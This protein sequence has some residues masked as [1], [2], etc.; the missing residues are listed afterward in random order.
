[1][2]KARFH[3]EIFWPKFDDYLDMV[4][5]A[6]TRPAHPCPITRLDIMLR[7]LVRELQR[8]S[9][10]KIGGIREQ[11]LMARELVL[12]LDRAQE[13][14]QLPEHVGELRR[15]MKMRCL[16]LSS[17]ERTMARQRSRVRQLSEGDANTAY[18][19]LIAR[20]RKRRNYIPALTVDGHVVTEHEGME[21]TLHTHFSGVFG[22]APER[23]IRLSSIIT[24]KIQD[25]FNV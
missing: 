18:F 17:L 10:T 24:S 14:R 15:R 13:T 23:A 20:G 4:S 6:W 3:F 2:S 1:M 11:L 8:W 21:S 25:L 12:Q 16:G 19:H 9:A 7:K 22:T 5:A